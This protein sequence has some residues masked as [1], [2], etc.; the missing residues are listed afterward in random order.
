M[1]PQN[2]VDVAIDVAVNVIMHDD[3]LR[4]SM[5]RIMSGHVASMSITIPPSLEMACESFRSQ[6][7]A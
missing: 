6:R 1:C 7:P 5:R 2:P 3:A 4:A